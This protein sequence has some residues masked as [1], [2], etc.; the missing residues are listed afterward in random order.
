MTAL[1]DRRRGNAAARRF[2]VAYA[3]SSIGSG[4]G[5]VALILVSYQHSHS[6][7]AVGAVVG[8][9]VAPAMALGPVFGAAADRL[10]RR[11]CLV[12]ADLVCAIA[13]LGIVVTHD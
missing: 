1:L 3:Q 7:W 6:S 10:P 9:G 12:A 4:V 11:A 13:F 2:F 8:A 5:Y